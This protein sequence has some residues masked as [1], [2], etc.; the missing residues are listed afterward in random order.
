MTNLNDLLGHTELATKLFAALSEPRTSVVRLT[1]PAGSGKSHVGMLVA[2]SWDRVGGRT[3]LAVGDDGQFARDHHPL[4]TALSS[5]PLRWGPLG[6]QASRSVV[7]AAGKVS[8]TGGAGTG[9]FD[10]L[11]SAARHRT[12]RALLAYSGVER[13]ILLDLRR[14]ARNRKLLLVADNLHWWDAA[15]LWLLDQLVS[16][17]LRRDLPALASVAVLVIDT[18]D[19]Q[20]PLAPQAFE[21]VATTAKATFRTRAC[22]R[23]R[24][25]EVLR[26]F[27]DP[28][29]HAS[30]E[31][32]ALF[33]ATG[34][35]LKLIEQLVVYGATASNTEP[36]RQLLALF[37]KR[38]AT[39]GG[40]AP[41]L[42]AMLGSAAVIGLVFPKRELECLLD[43]SADVVDEFI[44]RAEQIRLVSRSDSLV[45]FSHDV[46][47]TA[48]FRQQAPAQL[49][50]TR[51]KLEECLSTLRPG[52]Y[53]TRASLLHQSGDHDRARSLL[54][55]AGVAKLRA[56]VPAPRVLR[57]V[58]AVRPDDAALLQFLELIH[59]GLSAVATGEFAEPLPRLRT[60]STD[61]SV[62]MA[63]ERTYLVA[64]CLI[65]SQTTQ[66]AREAAKLLSSWL[67]SLRSELELQQRFLLLRQ[68]AEVLA[69]DFP[70]A[71]ATEALLERRLLARARFDEGA[72]R[73]LQVQN[74]RAGAVNTPEIA[75]VRVAEA[76]RYFR[77]AAD[78]RTQDR[79]EC[80]RSLTN[81]VAIQLR[82][83]K[84]ADAWATTLECED[85][86]VAGADVLPRLDVFANNAVLA[87]VRSGAMALKDAVERQHQASSSED[88]G[89]DNF[90]HRCN[91]AAY[92]TLGG[93]HGGA[94]IELVALREELDGN[95]YTETY[96]Q[97]YLGAV[98]VGAA[99]LGGRREEA[100]DRHASLGELV[101]GLGWSAAP[102]VQRRQR[103]L[104]EHLSTIDPSNPLVADVALLDAHPFEI[105]PAWSY[106]GRLVPLCELSFWSES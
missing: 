82:L 99:L 32:D 24:F 10:V 14:L 6:S 37:R 78:M 89:G 71:R 12:D 54:A 75:E 104:G 63:A 48:L 105:G 35:H 9:V 97:Y 45:E 66:G 49:R 33:S 58:G 101:A 92:L 52:D 18:A 19:E 86:V 70:A 22:T 8:G 59:H 62:E 83:G 103:L 31:I 25:P 44:E 73:A 87:G 93:D 84:D 34:G 7:Q 41:E 29:E 85:L 74:R 46:V 53:A 42:V 77:R 80:Y 88:A 43:E 28:T 102:Y 1:G 72:A 96:L 57:M 20:Q 69:E 27:G 81:L 21:A 4:L 100:Q 3:L 36:D 2:E 91:L 61:E 17:R 16:D 64:L 67:P 98:E 50:A 106:Y 90:I 13:D 68:Q 94:A 30:N 38:L 11:T 55:L 26:E 95:G 5:A 65:E 60:T 79:L 51:R 15:S 76:V 56:G 23:D 40:A 39:L 47:R